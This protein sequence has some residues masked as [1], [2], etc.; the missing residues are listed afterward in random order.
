M[1]KRGLSGLLENMF[2]MSTQG[3]RVSD[4]GFGSCFLVGDLGV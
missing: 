3:F 4:P 1:R 2:L